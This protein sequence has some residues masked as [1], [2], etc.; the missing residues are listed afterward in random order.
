M[1]KQLLLA[2]VGIVMG[3]VIVFAA[4]GVLPGLQK[5]AVLFLATLNNYITGGAG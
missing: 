5:S 1:S 4:I 3:A 2:I